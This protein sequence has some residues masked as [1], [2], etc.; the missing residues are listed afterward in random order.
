MVEY[1]DF[2]GNLG[3]SLTN[4]LPSLTKLHLSPYTACFTITFVNFAVSGLTSIRHLPVGSLLS[5]GLPPRTI[6]HRQFFS[7][8]PV[9]SFCF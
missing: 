2:A 7:E 5:P 3:S 1:Q 8:L 9:L 6:A 4:I